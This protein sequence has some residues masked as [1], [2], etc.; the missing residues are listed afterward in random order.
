[1]LSM[2]PFETRP[3]AAKPVARRGGGSINVVKPAPKP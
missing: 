2:T 1:M 3:V